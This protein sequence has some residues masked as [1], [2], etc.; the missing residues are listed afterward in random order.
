MD[1][2]NHEQIKRLRDEYLD[3]YK[4]QRRYLI[5]IA[6][7]VGFMG[8]VAGFLAGAIWQWK[9]F[10]DAHPVITVEPEPVAEPES[11]QIKI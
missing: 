1:E 11:T 3:L 4:H 7:A 10:A 9:Q 5:E 2:F 6:I 8:L